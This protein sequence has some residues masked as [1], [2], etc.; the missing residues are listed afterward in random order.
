MQ[1]VLH[2][3][4]SE[5]TL[6]IS[7]PP[8]NPQL[9]REYMD[10]LVFEEFGFH[11][12]ACCLAPSLAARAF[13]SS[14][15]ESVL[16]RTGYGIV[17]DSGFS[18]THIVPFVLGQ[19]HTN[20]I[21]RIDVG[22]KMLTN[23][24]KETISFRHWNMM[25]EYLLVNDIK[26]KA[27]SISLDF[28]ADLKRA[29][30]TEF[31][32]LQYVLPSGGGTSRFGSIRSSACPTSKDDQILSLSN[33]RVSVPELLFHPSDIGLRQM[34]VAEAIA[35]IISKLDAPSAAACLRN[36]VCCG[37]TT[38]IPNFSQRLLQDVRSMVPQAFEV[39]VVQMDNPASAAWM[40]GA[41]LAHTPTMQQ[42][43]IS[44]A[45]YEEKGHMACRQKMHQI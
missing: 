15:P 8:F 43:V 45:E 33:E 11:S 23:Y 26:E 28:C 7:E 18:F 21:R 36:I 37:G 19:P 39:N 5:T 25:D 34:G 20:C 14:H 35:D 22:G 1:D 12:Y 38:S 27:C 17:V 32:K 4:P 24:L 10:Q 41:E 31:L 13:S 29:K 2:V 9:L 42:I 44:R 6:I 3:T 30:Q 16:A 40:G